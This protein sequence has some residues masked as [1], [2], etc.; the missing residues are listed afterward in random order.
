M[1]MMDI[2]Q[3]KLVNDAAGHTAGDEMLKQLGQVIASNVP[4]D[5]QVARVSGDDFIILLPGYKLVEGINLAEALIQT[6]SDYRFT[7]KKQIFSISVCIGIV[8]Y[9]PNEYTP[10]SLSLAADTAFYAAKAKGHN[11]LSIYHTEDK[12]VQQYTTDVQTV[13]IIK[14]ALQEGDARFE[15][16]AQAIVPFQKDTGQVSYEILL[17]LKNAEGEMVYPDIFLPAANRYQMMVEIDT[18]V[19]RK[20][21]ETVTAHPEHIDKLAFVNI[22]MGGSTLNNSEFQKNIRQAIEEFNFPWEKLV[23]EVTET[24]AVGNLAQASDFICYCRELGIRVALD[25]FGTG[26]A[27]FEYLKHLPLDVVKIDG[28]FVRDMVDDP[29]DLAMVSYVH[30]ISKLRGQ[31]TI[32]EFVEEQQHVDELKKIGIDYGQGYF[33]EKPKPLSAWIEQTAD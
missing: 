33:L 26:M 16:F 15:L 18:Y 17:R 29:V 19:L 23:L 3:F 31:E 4:E 8:S 22:N 9:M 6:L 30:D 11:Q 21:L 28:S 25:D 13:A 10:Q 32:A 2:D 7:W 5:A 20:Y 12:N 27:S 14:D 24:S 1:F